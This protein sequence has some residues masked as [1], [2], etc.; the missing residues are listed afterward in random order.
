VK[1]RGRVT[2]PRVGL[3]SLKTAITGMAAGGLL[4]TLSLAAAKRGEGGWRMDWFQVDASG[5][6]AVVAIVGGAH[7]GSA[8]VRHATYCMVVELY[9]DG[10]ERAEMGFAF[11]SASEP[12]VDFEKGRR[13][14][15]EN[16][17]KNWPRWDRI[18][19]WLA[20]EAQFGGWR[21]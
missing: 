20:Y 7:E 9:Q 16:A 12:C 18:D 21:G 10:G 5:F 2:V 14:S 6:P 11:C 13:I 1:A 17:L 19:A 8:H 15:L 3:E 4:P